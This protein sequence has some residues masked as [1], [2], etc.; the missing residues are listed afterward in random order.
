MQLARRLHPGASAGAYRV[1]PAGQAAVEAGL[2]A[3]GRE[4]AAA[5]GKQLGQALVELADHEGL[6]GAEVRLRTLGAG[7][8]AVPDFHLAVARA[9][10]QHEL[11]LGAAGQQR[12]QR[13]R[14]GEAAEVIEVGVLPVAVLGVAVAP[15]VQGRG[16]QR[17]GI[18][19]D[20]PHQGLAAR[21]EF[22]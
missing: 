9:A 7:A 2:R 11:A 3:H 1:Q 15:V 21:G 20:G 17:H 12:D 18:G 5:A 8:V 16:H 14:L 22:G 13:L 10:E 4:H 19:A 6:V